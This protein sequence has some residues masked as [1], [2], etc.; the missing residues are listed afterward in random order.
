MDSGWRWGNRLGDHCEQHPSKKT[1]LLSVQEI[2][3]PPGTAHSDGIVYTQGSFE[4]AS[5]VGLVYFSNKI[6]DPSNNG[7]SMGKQTGHCVEVEIGEELAC[8]FNFKFETKLFGGRI[9]AEATFSLPEF[10]NANLVITGGTGDFTGIVG[11][12][13]TRKVP[14]SDGTTFIYDFIFKLPRKRFL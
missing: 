9:T 4:N 13:C 2:Q 10:P 12:A 7:T 14:G 3:S 8:Y 6:V 11:S 1:F 5:S